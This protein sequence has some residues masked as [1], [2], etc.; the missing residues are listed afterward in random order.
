VH[1]TGSELHSVV[2]FGTDSVEPPGSATTMLVNVSCVSVGTF[3]LLGSKKFS[4]FQYLQWG[5][6]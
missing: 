3:A 6:L 5:T 4:V 2:G 1:R